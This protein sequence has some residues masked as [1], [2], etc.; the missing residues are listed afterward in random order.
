MGNLPSRPGDFGRYVPEG[1]KLLVNDLA[2]Q[3]E[4]AAKA[5]DENRVRELIEAGADVNGGGI[6]PFLWACFK[7]H[8]EIVRLCIANG[9]NVNY[10]GFDEGTLLMTA[11]LNGDTEF[12]DYLI[13]VGAEVNLAMPLGGETALHHAAY[14]N[15]PKSVDR[16]L[17]HGAIINQRAKSG[18]TTALNNFRTIH[19]DTPLHIAAV[20]AGKTLI[21]RL[22]SASADNTITNANGKTPFDLAK[23][24]ERTSEILEVL[25]INPSKGT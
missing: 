14:A 23:E 7:G 19:G 5:G 25:A 21:E 20:C 2:E 16:L 12:I 24:H 8:K 15:K 11:S 3:L 4:K 13:S 18:G 1:L 22:L 10:D 6:P 9:A 17:H